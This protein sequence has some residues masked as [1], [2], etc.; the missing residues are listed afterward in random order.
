MRAEDYRRLILRDVAG[1]IREVR[2]YP[3]EPDLW[4]TPAGV[5]NPPGNLALHVAGNL[6]HNVGHHLGGIE[7]TRD[8]DA[9]FSRREVPVRE[10]VAELEAASNAVDATLRDFPDSRLDEP[11]PMEVG[12]VQMSTGRFL[13]HICGHLAYHLGQVDYHRRITTGKGSIEGIQGLEP[14]KN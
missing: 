9:E 12:G 1:L 7:Y 11:F 2:A 10:L 6:R 3:D 13:A 5:G 4:S 8:R 14:L